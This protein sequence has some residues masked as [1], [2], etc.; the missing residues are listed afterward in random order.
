M[1]YVFYQ[2]AAI[3]GFDSFG[4]YLRAG[5]IVNTCSTY[6]T[7]PAPGCTANVRRE[8]RRAPRR[9]S[10]GAARPGARRHVEAIL[11]RR[12]RRDVLRRGPTRSRRA[13]PARRARGA[14]AAPTQAPAAPPR[15]ARPPRRGR[16]TRRAGRRADARA[17]SRPRL[18]VREGRAVSNRG[19]GHRRQPRPDRRGHGARGRRRG[20]PVLQRQPGPAVRARPTTLKV[21]VPSAANL[22]RGNEVRIGGA[23]V[24]VGRR[25][26][27][28]VRN[29]DGSSVAMLDA[30]AREATPSR[31][32]RTRR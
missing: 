22:V 29:D 19:A 25:D 13:T 8:R 3:N 24:G 12:G 5:L 28:R 27:R 14:G 11:A 26:R 2:V 31:C 16:P 4:H 32:R 17:T 18:P 23:R 9:P 7:D 10:E 30:Q 15:R 20:V 6:A 21:E 1:D